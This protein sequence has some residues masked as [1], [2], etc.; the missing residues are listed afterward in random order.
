MRKE[1]VRGRVTYDTLFKR[2]TQK[3]VLCTTDWEG[4]VDANGNPKPFSR[5]EIEGYY[6]T[7]PYL[8]KDALEAMEDDEGEDFFET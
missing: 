1:K 5:H 4:I 3:L 8:R 6:A 2:Q 7:N